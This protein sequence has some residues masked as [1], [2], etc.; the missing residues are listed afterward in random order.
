LNHI[1]AVEE[2]LAELSADHIPRLLVL[3]KADKIN[4]SEIVLKRSDGILISA[5]KGSGIDIL[6]KRIRDCLMR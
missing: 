6:M 3:N 5:A 4:S 1:E 2:V